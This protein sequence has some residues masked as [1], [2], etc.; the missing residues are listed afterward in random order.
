MVSKNESVW[1]EPIPAL[2]CWLDGVRDLELGCVDTGH[3][4]DGCHDDD[5]DDDGEVR[6]KVPDAA[7]EITGRPEVLQGETDSERPGEKNHGHQKGA[8]VFIATITILFKDG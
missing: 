8:V 3:V 5:A 4:V 2:P 7:R 1:D 6:E